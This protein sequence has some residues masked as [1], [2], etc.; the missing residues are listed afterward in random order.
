MPGIHV[1][2]F[3]GLAGNGRRQIVVGRADRQAGGRIAEGFEEFE[4]AVGMAGLAFGGRAEHGG[5]IV[6]AFDVGLLRE[7][8]IA[9]VGLDSPANAS[10]RLSSVL[11]PLSAAITGSFRQ[12]PGK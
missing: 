4:V 10:F 1:G 3:V 5:D 7:I 9:A 12:F 11:L 8:Q 2:V 6:V